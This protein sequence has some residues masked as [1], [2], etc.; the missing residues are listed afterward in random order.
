VDFSR[1]EIDKKSPRSPHSQDIEAA[2][3]VIL[4]LPPGANIDAFAITD[5]SFARPISLLTGHIPIDH[6]PLT[7]I[8]QIQ[9]AKN[10]LM[11]QLRTES[12]SI[13]P[14]FQQTDVIGFLVLVGHIMRSSD[15]HH[16][17]IIFSDM[18]NC[19]RDLDI[20]TPTLVPVTAALQTAKR[21]NLIADLK[22]VDV[23]VLGV[24]PGGKSIQYASTLEQFWRAYFVAAGANLRT[25]SVLRD[26]PDLSRTVPKGDHP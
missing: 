25:F 26:P 1:S 15:G 12:L 7:F 16:V 18:R 24:Y 4:R 22:K 5:Q 3:Q 13:S 17:L 2:T 10:R 6:G 19:T 20:E 23:F 11:K 14:N 8:D 21:R 9:I